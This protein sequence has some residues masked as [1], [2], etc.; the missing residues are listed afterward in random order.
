M[1]MRIV[2]IAGVFPDCNPRASRFL[3]D[4]EDLP[5][6]HHDMMLSEL[7]KPVYIHD[8]TGTVA[9]CYLPEDVVYHLRDEHGWENSDFKST[10]AA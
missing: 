9:T 1:N 8:V 10:M 7:E 4:S 6:E 5:K 2:A 3:L